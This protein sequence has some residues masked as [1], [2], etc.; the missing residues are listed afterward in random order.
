MKELQ[1][2]H[3]LV[4]K[5]IAEKF[6]IVEKRNVSVGRINLTLCATDGELDVLHLWG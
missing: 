5:S 6:E 2:V 1:N 4:R 3:L